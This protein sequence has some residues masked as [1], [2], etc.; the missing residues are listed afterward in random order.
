M[1]RF[2]LN[3]RLS[4][5]TKVL[6]E[7]SHPMETS[8]PVVRA[9]H[10]W[11]IISEQLRDL[12]GREIHRQWFRSVTP[13]LISENILILSTPSK[14]A[15]H[16]INNHYQD[17]VDLLISFQDKKLST[18]FVSQEDLGYHGSVNWARFVETK[19]MTIEEESSN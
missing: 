19:E 3:T 15:C 5:L 1:K 4:Y 16:W 2:D 11:R 9:S 12:L 6:F 14:Q 7:G 18:F 17:L 8:N 10:A 13:V